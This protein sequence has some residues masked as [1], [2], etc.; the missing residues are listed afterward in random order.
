MKVVFCLSFPYPQDRRMETGEMVARAF[1]LPLPPPVGTAV[2]IEYEWKT[3]V[4]GTTL[5]IGPEGLHALTYLEDYP[6]RDAE[7][8]RAT[9]KSYRKAGWTYGE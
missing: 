2:E 3:K 5:V 7:E 6:V 1:E 9:A 8:S 4:K